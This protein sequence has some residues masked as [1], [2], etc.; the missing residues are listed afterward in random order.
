MTAN[1]DWFEPFEEEEEEAV[2]GPSPA[3]ERLRRRRR[4]AKPLLP[5]WLLAVGGLVVVLAIAL[6]W[7]WAAK[8]MKESKEPPTIAITPT[9]TVVVPTATLAPTD[10]PTPLLTSTPVPAM[11][12]P[13]A[14]IA[15]GGWVKVIGTGDAG[16]SYR[17]GP[18]LENVRL[19]IVKD[20]VVLKVLD[21]PRESDGYTWWRLEE[22]VDGQPGVVGWA[23]E[24]FLQPTSA[25]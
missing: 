13:P 2:P 4:R 15:V 20:G 23:V 6:L 18:G 21:G 24:D 22:Y 1:D 25:P 17:A 9:F 7:V 19:K 8:A 12:T 3:V 5:W 10:V 16:L 11:P 14:D